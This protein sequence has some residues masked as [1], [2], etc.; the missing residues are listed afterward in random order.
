MPLT[1][2]AVTEIAQMI[3]N[4]SPTPY[5]NANSY[6]GVGDSTDVFDATENDLQAPTNK[7]RVAVDATFPS[8]VGDVLTF[9]S[10]FATGQ[11]NWAW[12][13]WA[14]FNHATTGTMLQRKVESLGTKTSA[15]SWELNVDLT[16]GNP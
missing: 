8:R 5:E 2:A 14:T 3:I 12:E 9:Q 7:L 11:A 15:Q 6:V 16:V 10:T 4:D 13:E 1:D